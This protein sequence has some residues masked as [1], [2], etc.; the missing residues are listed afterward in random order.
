MQYTILHTSE[1]NQFEIL[2]IK[3]K[4]LNSKIENNKRLKLIPAKPTSVIKDEKLRKT[5]I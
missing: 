3:N 2:S 1:S 5:P 4:R